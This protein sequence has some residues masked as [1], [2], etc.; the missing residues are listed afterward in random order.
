MSDSSANPILRRL[1]GNDGES[2]ISTK[3]TQW[4]YGAWCELPLPP[5]CPPTT[6]KPPHGVVMALWALE[7]SHGP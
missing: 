6:Y 4:A 7:D 5:W 2:D 3:P 1:T